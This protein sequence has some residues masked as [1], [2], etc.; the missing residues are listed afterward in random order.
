MG[1]LPTSLQGNKYIFVITD[2]FTEWVE[3]FPLKDT[4][5]TT[6]AIVMLNEIVCRSGVPSCL[7][8]DQVANLCSSVVYSLCELL[9]IATIRTPAYHPEGIDQVERFNHTLESILAEI[10]HADQDDWDSQLPKALF[11]YRTAVCETTDFTPF[12]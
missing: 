7:H 8:R 5:A 3:A 4:T 10:I 12:T 1:H 2:L 9:R 11:A 6:L